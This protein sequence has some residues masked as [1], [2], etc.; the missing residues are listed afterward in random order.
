MP[1]R[2]RLIHD[3]PHDGP[4]NMARDEALLKCVGAG[5]SPP[6][7]R[8]YRWAPPTIS[9]GYFQPYAAYEALEPPA[10]RLPVVRRQT[11]GGAILHDQE[12]TYAIV[13]P[14]GHRLA[15]GATKLYE[16]AHDA[17]IHALADAGMAT[18]RGCR[19]DDS[20]PGRGPFFCFARR[21]CLDVL[22]GKEKLAGSAQRRTRRAVLQHGSIVFERRYD[23]QPAAAIG[24]Y[25]NLDGDRFAE[26]WTRSLEAIGDLLFEPGA[27]TPEE[28]GRADTLRAKYADPAWTRRR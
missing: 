14:I 28:L 6:T 10:G 21:H 16:V 22:A 23:Q 24:E 3:G 26:L 9:L 18:W 12:L 17:V 5:Q 1:D 8:L 19:S 13:L 11:G 15:H 27:C 2:I 4:T 20:T 25:V 7:L